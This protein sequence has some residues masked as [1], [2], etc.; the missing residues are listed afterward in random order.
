[1]KRN[2][3]FCLALV[4]AVSASAQL[5]ESD[6]YNAY[7]NGNVATSTTG[8]VA[9]QGGMMLLGGA[10]SDYQI[11]SGDAAH[12]K[13]LQVTGGIEGT[14]TSS[15]AVFKG[16]FATAWAARTPGN[17]I[18]KGKVE[19]F[20]GTSTNKHVSGVGVFG[21]TDG[22]VGIRYNSQT[23]T[24]NGLAYLTVPGG[25]DGFYNI[26]GITASTY[27]ANTWV[28]LVYTYNKTT[29]DI[30]YKIANEP[31]ITLE[32][33]GASTVA[34]L[35][36]NRFRVL[37]SP[38]RT[39]A[40]DPVNTGATTFGI[41]NYTVVAS[42]NTTL[43]TSDVESKKNSMI[44]IGPN[45]TADYLNILTSLKINNL[46]IYDMSGRKVS[47]QLEGNKVDVKHLNPGSY[48]V[49]FETKDGKT[50]EKFIKK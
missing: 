13:Y 30:T 11:V 26:T 38:T 42:N 24:I 10:V 32:I 29:G 43:G 2:L 20:T 36:P 1:M 40:T 25:D 3:L 44:A 39:S 16:N 9:G 18:V 8:T 17:N 45:P 31:E 35:E 48:I 28:T 21:V 15:R 34:N 22:I 23:K 27:P 46:E 14:A 6:N 50:T 12:G 41:D 19:I 49:T 37:S 47:S 4:S 5:L 7:T 33:D